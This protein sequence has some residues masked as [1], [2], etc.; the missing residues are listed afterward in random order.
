MTTAQQ[1]L[2]GLAGVAPG[3][4][5]V[6]VVYDRL[7]STLGHEPP[8]SMARTTVLVPT[9]RMQR[10][11]KALF[12]EDG[13]CL[14][15]RFGL[16]S[17]VSA[18]LPVPAPQSP[19]PW[20]RRLL[21]VKAL[22]DRLIALDDR[23]SESASVDLSQSLV[24]LLDEM[25]G[26]G[27]PF[28]ALEDLNPGI[29]SDHWDRNLS[30]LR[31]IKDY[32]TALPSEITDG[33]ALH[34]RNVETLCAEWQENGLGSRIVL[35]GSTGSRA[36][37]RMLMSALIQQPLGC[38]VLPGFDFGLPEDVWASLSSDAA[39]EDHPQFRFAAFLKDAGCSATDVAQWGE[40]GANAAN[41]LIS[42]SLRPAPVT[43][44]WLIEGPKLGHLE[45]A[46]RHL[47]L[48]EAK[49]PREEARAIA[50][51]I[52]AA[53]EDGK[54]IAVISPDATLSRRI[55][56]ALTTWNI[57]PD[58]SG[59]VPLGLTPGG[60][61][62]RHVLQIAE[63]TDD[64]V[65][66]FALLKH[67]FTH[68][69][70]GRGPH[71]LATQEFEFYIRRKR[72]ATVTPA[73]IHQFGESK[74]EFA[75]WCDWL[76]AGL[77]SVKAPDAQDVGAHFDNH[78]VI[79]Q[80]FLGAEGWAA[81]LKDEAGDRIAD[82]LR[83]FGDLRDVTMPIPRQDYRRLFEAALSAETVRPTVTA[84]P[85]VMIWG[86]LEARVQG[87]DVVVL[88]GLNEGIWPQHPK[89][90][91]WLNRSM[92]AELGLLLPERQIGLA[93]HDYQQ[94]IAARQVILT[95]SLRATGSETVPS[96]WLNR[97]TNLLN[98]LPQNGGKTALTNMKQRGHQLVIDAAAQEQP[99]DK[100][101]DPKRPAPI[102]PVDV[103]PLEFG[104]TEIQK[105]IRDPYD[106]Y[107]RRILRLSQLDP[108]N[109]DQDIREKGIVFHKIM[110][111]FLHPDHPFDD[112]A[113]QRDRLRK[114]ASQ[115]FAANTIGPVNAADWMAHLD[116]IADW[117]IAG[118]Q[119]RRKES[120]GA[121]LEVKGTYP[122][123]QTRHVLIGKADR[124][125]QTDDD[126]AVIYDY[127]TGKPPEKKD[128]KYYDRQ[129]VLEALM[130]EAGGFKDL[131]ARPVDH[132][133]HISLSR[134]PAVEAISL[135]G[136]YDLVT[137]SGELAQL[138]NGFDDPNKGYLARRARQKQRFEGDF[139]HLSRFG[140]WDETHPASPE[141]LK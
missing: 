71:M 36:T 117:L 111:L 110:E 39:Y 136:P 63:H 70:D 46:T 92:R 47:T 4:D 119:Q 80:A 45:D 3:Q 51:G 124:I 43:D 8:E 37:T 42:L 114:I 14:L 101:P 82:I 133:A 12:V 31:A 17:D 21:D 13:A 50:M 135:D 104:V 118:E 79:A 48:V 88:A 6:R 130:L 27:V 125:D 15:P 67:P 126:L 2:T 73:C 137:V 103:R 91:P 59:G 139:D 77:A 9:R 78:T 32:V 97:L 52:R 112:A 10:R 11:L 106:I 85:D 40:S 140:E 76:V 25:H 55:A 84:R 57:T 66:L 61:F 29:E 123:P 22:V 38:V 16:V 89:S 26:E 19:V 62:L 75:G 20:L 49:E 98:G 102:P 65:K 34:R 18:L 87:A 44:K 129:L 7:I 127:K 113:P 121:K 107:A 1:P 83:N 28:D 64:A 54:S 94:A 69:G 60:R 122:V 93:A 81:L 131:P 134:T 90:D 68:K 109:P 96:R 105:L 116:G 41:D 58:D 95:R 56:A 138:L 24:A 132:V 72:I 74:A 115:V 53:L 30:F 86:T 99:D 23:L 120:L 141:V 33:E 35:A 5:F 108:F 100:T 128:I